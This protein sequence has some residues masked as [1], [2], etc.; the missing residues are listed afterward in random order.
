M[1]RPSKLK[2]A[3]KEIEDEVENLK[4]ERLG[5]ECTITDRISTIEMLK[6]IDG[7]KN[8]KDNNNIR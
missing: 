5:I 3:I 1:S 2:R 8:E 7:E 6:K 4:R